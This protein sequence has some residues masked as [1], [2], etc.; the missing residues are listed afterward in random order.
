MRWLLQSAIAE[1]APQPKEQSSR[2]RGARSR[3]SPKPSFGALTLAVK[4]RVTELPDPRTTR[5]RRASSGRRSDFRFGLADGQRQRQRGDQT[6]VVAPGTTLVDEPTPTGTTRPIVRWPFRFCDGYRP[7]TAGLHGPSVSSRQ[8]PRP[9]LAMPRAPACGPVPSLVRPETKALDRLP[10]LASN[11][12][13]VVNRTGEV[14]GD[15]PF[16]ILGSA[17]AA[18]TS[19]RSCTLPAAATNRGVTRSVRGPGISQASRSGVRKAE[20]D[21]D[22]RLNDGVPMIRSAARGMR[23]GAIEGPT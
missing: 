2:R 19:S 5:S 6:R 3:N 22:E 23:T 9:A 17:S 13:L 21:V 14:A 11:G 4:G 15:P 10:S 1:V 7:R 20:S 8:R 18:L 16:A 12:L